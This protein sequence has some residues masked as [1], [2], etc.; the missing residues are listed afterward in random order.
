MNKLFAKI[1]FKNIAIILMIAIFFIADRFLKFLANGKLANSSFKLINDLFTFNFS[2]NH[3]IAFSLP[4]YGPWLNLIIGLIILI[5]IHFLIKAIK[6]KE[7]I[8]TAGLSLILT[9]AISNLIDRLLFGYV[10]DYLYLKYFTIFNLA[11]VYI[12][13]GAILIIISLY[14]KPGH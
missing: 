3:F 6:N 2:A 11:D 12:S 9:G 1:N 4:L 13:V 8:I 5:L 10:I 7:K 14:K